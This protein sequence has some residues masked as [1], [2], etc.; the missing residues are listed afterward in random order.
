MKKS[1]GL[2]DNHGRELF[3]GDHFVF[4][5]NRPWMCFGK[6]TGITKGGNLRYA[7]YRG[8]DE[9]DYAKFTNNYYTLCTN[10]YKVDCLAKEREE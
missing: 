4:F 2:K 9:D 6:I 5:P 8:I 1:L 10:Y 7:Q 3:I